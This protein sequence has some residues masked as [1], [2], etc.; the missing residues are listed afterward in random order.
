MDSR[1]AERRRIAALLLAELAGKLPE[2]V[3]AAL[4]SL[5]LNAEEL[6]LQHAVL[7]RHRDGRATFFADATRDMRAWAARQDGRSETLVEAVQRIEA[8]AAA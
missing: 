5:I 4:E 7:V 2:P 8:Q 6:R 3:L 1:H